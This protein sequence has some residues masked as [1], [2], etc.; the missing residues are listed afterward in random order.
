MNEYI[1][2][3]Y[4]WVLKNG[5]TVEVEGTKDGVYSMILYKPGH[6]GGR[7]AWFKYVDTAH[8]N[9]RPRNSHTGK[10]DE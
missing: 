3:M 2:S 5:G 6:P 8:F 10:F 1:K 4:I 7:M 9:L